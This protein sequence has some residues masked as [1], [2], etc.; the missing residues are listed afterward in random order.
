MID[1][2]EQEDWPASLL[3]ETLRVSRSAYYAWRRQEPSAR[4][5]ADHQLRPLIRGNFREHRRRYGARRIAAELRERGQ[6]CSRR[7]ASHLMAEMGLDAIQPKSSMQCTTD[8]RE[9]LGSSPNLLLDAPPPQSVLPQT[10]L[11]FSFAVVSITPSEGGFH[12]HRSERIEFRGAQ[13]LYA[14]AESGLRQG[15]PGRRCSDLGPVRPAPYSVDSVLAAAEAAVG[16]WMGCVRAED[17]A[18]W[19]IGR[20]AEDRGPAGEAGD[21]ERGHRRADAES[22]QCITTQTTWAEHTAMLRS[23]PS[24]DPGVGVMRC[25]GSRIGASPATLHFNTNAINLRGTMPRS[26]PAGCSL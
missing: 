12:G 11:E 20:A 26:S 7:R 8:S 23:K 1:E 17:K 14:A 24:A 4:R 25:A 13:A 21:Q 16:A 22:N 9:A 6:P 2:L 3:C 18:G 10:E 19:P 15:A 5:R